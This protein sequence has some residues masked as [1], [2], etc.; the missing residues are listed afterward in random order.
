MC[1]CVCVLYV[2]C[3]VYVYA[4]HT[5]PYIT[6]HHH[7]SPCITTHHTHTQARVYTQQ[8]SL[9]THPSTSSSPSSPPHHPTIPHTLNTHPH[10]PLYC[11]YKGPHAACPMGGPLP[12]DPTSHAPHHK[13]H[14]T[15]GGINHHSI[16]NHG[17]WCGVWMY[18]WPLGVIVCSSWDPLGVGNPHCVVHWGVCMCWRL[19]MCSCHHQ[20]RY[21]WVGRDGV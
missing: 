12:M 2:C 13:P 21:V 7:T 3:I 8:P 5:S 15:M 9:Q 1:V 16:L 17:G 11:D 19:L 10:H 4:H 14:I 18:R 20:T 6:I